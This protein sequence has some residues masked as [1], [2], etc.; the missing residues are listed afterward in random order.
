MNQSGPHPPLRRSPRSGATGNDRMSNVIDS[1]HGMCICPTPSAPVLV[2][3]LV[4]VHRPRSRLP[5]ACLPA[6]RHDCAGLRSRRGMGA[7][8]LAPYNPILG[9]SPSCRWPTEECGRISVTVHGTHENQ[10]GK[11][12]ALKRPREDHCGPDP[13][14]GYLIRRRRPPAKS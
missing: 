4:K 3:V 14:S 6:L 10:H 13:G 7:L 5:M 2:R 11:P 8:G 1:S 9:A 12:R